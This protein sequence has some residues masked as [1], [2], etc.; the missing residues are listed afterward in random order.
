MLTV[1]GSVNTVV[2]A[3]RATPIVPDTAVGVGQ[4]ACRTPTVASQTTSVLL[5]A[6]SVICARATIASFREVGDQI[7]PFELKAQKAVEWTNEA[8]VLDAKDQAHR[9]RSCQR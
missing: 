2:V 9:N 8:G 5:D 3:A 1:A 4:V 6:A 7:R